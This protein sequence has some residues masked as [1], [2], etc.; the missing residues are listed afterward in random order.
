[1]LAGDL[2]NPGEEALGGRAATAIGADAAEP[3]PETIFVIPAHRRCSSQSTQK[4]GKISGGAAKNPANAA[5][6]P[7]RGTVPPSG[8][9]RAPSPNQCA[10]HDIFARWPK[11]VPSTLIL[12]STLST[13]SALLLS[14][15]SESSL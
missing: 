11:V 8:R 15:F 12:P 5:V 7:R 3:R 9:C 14:L 4:H 13:V 6:S 1:M 10:D 2:A